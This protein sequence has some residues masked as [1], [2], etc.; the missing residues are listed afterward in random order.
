MASTPSVGSASGLHLY[1]ITGWAGS[2]GQCTW[3]LYCYPGQFPGGANPNKVLPPPK[4]HAQ[5][6]IETEGRAEAAK[7]RGLDPQRLEAAHAECVDMEKQGVIRLSKSHWASP[8]H[9]VK[10]ADGTWRPCGDFR[11]LNL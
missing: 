11:R 9:M 3:G 5:H 8:L 10:K 4:H 1:T 2:S 6:F 7:Y